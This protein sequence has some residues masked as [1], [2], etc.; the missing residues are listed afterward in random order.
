MDPRALLGVKLL[1]GIIAGLSGLV[2]NSWI[3]H[4]IA[5]DWR[6][7]VHLSLPDQILT[8][9]GLIDITLQAAL[10]FDMSSIQSQ[11]YTSYDQIH[12]SF[13]GFMMFLVSTNVW[14]TAWLSI[15]YCMRIVNFTDGILFICKMRICTFL[16]KLQVV[17]TVGSFILSFAS[18]WNIYPVKDQEV[19]G[20]STCNLTKEQTSILVTSPYLIALL[21]GCIL[22][23]VLTLIPIGLTLG[24][25]WRHLKRM[26]KNKSDTCQPRTQAH[27]R[28]ARTMVLQVSLHTGQA[29]VIITGNA[30]LIK[31]SKG[32]V[33]CQYLYIVAVIHIV[34]KKLHN[35][36]HIAS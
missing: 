6:R 15:Y 7:G 35:A 30:K 23:L 3:V 10:S 13:L 24:S 36:N 31:A 34:P 4:V 22:P 16:P 11:L 29:L 26:N 8:F 28:A 21:L 1:V 17:S 9:M 27:V 20:N 12:L 19:F 33:T 5:K 25:L 18:F 32:A 14:L 2:F